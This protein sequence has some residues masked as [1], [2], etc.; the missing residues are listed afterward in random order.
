MNTDST[1]QESPRHLDDGQNKYVSHVEQ[2][3]IITILT[4]SSAPVRA[5]YLRDVS[6]FAKTLTVPVAAAPETAWSGAAVPYRHLMGCSNVDAD[7]HPRNVGVGTGLT[8]K[9]H[10]ETTRLIK[11]PRKTLWPSE[12]LRG[13]SRDAKALSVYLAPALETTWRRPL[14]TN[15]SW[16]AMT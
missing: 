10:V 11:S 8:K 4:Q 1:T 12:D 2:A 3:A 14:A 13:V 7:L 9:A 5:D 15:T 16:G 6:R